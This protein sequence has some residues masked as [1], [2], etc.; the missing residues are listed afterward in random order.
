MYI[1]RNLLVFLEVLFLINILLFLF[2]YFSIKKFKKRKEEIREMSLLVEKQKDDAEKSFNLE[3]EKFNKQFE[4][5]RRK[6]NRE[7]EEMHNYIKEEKN[8]LYNMRMDFIKEL[9]EKE[10]TKNKTD[11]EIAIDSLFE[12]RKMWHDLKAY[13]DEVNGVNANVLLKI[14]NVESKVSDLR[15]SSDEKFKKLSQKLEDQ[16]INEMLTESQVESLLSNINSVDYSDVCRAVSSELDD[17]NIVSLINEAK[18]E[19]LSHLNG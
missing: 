15:A 1:N 13:R 12:I 17:A 18:D 11:K 19:I 8:K 3:K 2:S 4:D 10:D 14:K 16:V 7:R 6:I 5:E 9:E